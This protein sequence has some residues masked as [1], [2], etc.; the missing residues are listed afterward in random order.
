MI[1]IKTSESPSAQR[2]MKAFSQFRKTHWNP[3][4]VHHLKPSEFRV[5]YT[6]ASTDDC[7]DSGLMVSQ[8][9]NSL[10]IAS[11]TVT[12]LVNGLKTKGLIKKSSDPDDKRVVR[13]KLS[14]KGK[15]LVKKASEEFYAKFNGLAG[16]LG[17][18]KSDEL[19]DLLFDV[20]SYFSIKNSQHTN[21]RIKND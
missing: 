9:S 2:L 7:N 3:R 20:S 10:G 15:G 13:I 21:E 17:E 1:V 11:P 14:E 18:K 4:H 6:I 8:I 5:L 12:Q 16:Y 19:A